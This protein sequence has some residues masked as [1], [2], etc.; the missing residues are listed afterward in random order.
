MAYANNDLNSGFLSKTILSARSMDMSSLN[1]SL[2]LFVCIKQGQSLE[3]ML[4]IRG[5]I[6]RMNQKSNVFQKIC[7]SNNENSIYQIN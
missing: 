4:L 3:L 7:F 1:S 2:T 5:I 6:D